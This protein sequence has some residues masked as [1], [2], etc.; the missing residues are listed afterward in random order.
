MPFEKPEEFLDLI[1]NLGFK[2]YCINELS[3]K[4]EGGN[5]SHLLKVVNIHKSLKNGQGSS[6]NLL[7]VKK[8]I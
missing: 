4:I 1:K 7:C 8:E 6:V 3:K 2:I 5:L